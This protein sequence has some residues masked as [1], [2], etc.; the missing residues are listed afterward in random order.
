MSDTTDV[1]KTV[2]ERVTTFLRHDLWEMRSSELPR[3]YRSG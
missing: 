2:W 3:L 1:K